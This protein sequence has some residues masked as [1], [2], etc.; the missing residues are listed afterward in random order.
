M[1]LN[2]Y[3]VFACLAGTMALQSCNDFLDTKPTE[4]YSDNLVWS[5][6][7]TVDAFVITNYGSASSPYTDFATIDNA[8][9]TN[10][11]PC[12]SSCPSEARGL[13]DRTWN[14]GFNRFTAIRNCNLIIEKVAGSDVLDEK[15]KTQYTAEAKMMRA[16]IYYDLARHSG[17]FIW[18]DRVLN[19]TDEFNL[20]LTANIVESYSKVLTDLREAIEGLPQTAVSG[21]LTKN[22]GLALLSEVCLTAA[23]YTN[24]DA[25]LHKATGTDLY[26]EAIAAVDAIEGVSL[27]ADYES[28]FNEKG[29]YNSP[30]IIMAT[31]YSKTNNN[32]MNTMINLMPNLL[33]DNLAKNDCGPLFKQADIFE[34]WLDYTP[35]QNLVDNYLVIDQKTGQA[36]RWNESSQFVENTSP[37]SL[38]DAAG[39]IT[40]KDPAELVDQT[41][42]AYAVTTADVSISDL[43]YQYRDKRFDATILHDGSSFYGETL[44]TCRLGN[45]S[46]WASEAYGADHVPL[47]NYGMRKSIYTN[48]S[49]RVFYN[50]PTDYH[51]VVFRY[52]RAVLNKAEAQLCLA[53]TDAS[54]LTAAIETFN[55]TRTIH[56]G[57]PAST[58]TTLQEA[59]TDYKRERRV[60]FVFEADYYWSLLRWGKYGYEANHGLAPGSTI[61]ELDEPAT[62]IEIATDRT[63]AYIGNVQ[64]QNDQ[65]TFNENRAYLFPITQTII[66]A[67]SAISDS[68][69]NPGW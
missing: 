13:R 69:Q 29:A 8:F 65:R 6:P 3:I 27:D 58:A 42:L 1:K 63:A 54:M 38:T 16:M 61:L 10:L 48:V 33:N 55:Q 62:F 23:A 44:A 21:R 26:R 43:M 30:E 25:S 4:T 64:F 67:N 46:R 32:C 24:N 14:W 51:K 19:T 36:V 66:N 7:S 20:P 15:Y 49:P 56:G 41:S 59:W 53:K 60:E 31:Y 22:A 18:V 34:G 52:G 68:D 9:T 12:R 45:F 35:S 11:V 37:I 5:S 39:R 57:L 50:T 17:R 28:I 40:P 47:T 2:Q